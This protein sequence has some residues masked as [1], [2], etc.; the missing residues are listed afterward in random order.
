M[1][2]Q[3]RGVIAAIGKREM[4]FKLR[5]QRAKAI[6]SGFAMLAGPRPGDSL[7]SAKR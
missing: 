1:R 6:D 3:A 5:E 7:E 4:A 2:G